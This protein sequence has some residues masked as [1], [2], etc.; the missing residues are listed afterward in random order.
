MPRKKKQVVKINNVTSLEGVLQEVY[1]EACGN[2]KDAQGIINELSN[3]TTPDDVDDH[4]KI[5]KAKTDAIKEKTT[6]IKVK[7]EVAKLQNDSVKHA[8]DV[9]ATL[10]SVADGEVTTDD[11]HAVKKLIKDKAAADK[12]AADKA[13]E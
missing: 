2:I 10:H 12:A 6:N 11:F 3:G 5:A 8:G 1:N 7:L 13:N 4:T 9:Q